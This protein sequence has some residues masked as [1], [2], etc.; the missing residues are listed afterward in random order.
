MLRRRCPA[1]VRLQ[2]SD[3][4]SASRSAPAS[5]DIRSSSGRA[6]VPS[7]DWNQSPAS[8]MTFS[9]VP[10]SSKRCVAPGTSF[11]ALSQD[12]TARACRFSPMTPWSSAPTISRVGAVT[13]AKCRA[14]EVGPTAA[15]DDR[16]HP[17]AERCRR[18]QSRGGPGAGAEEAERQAGQV[19][20]LVDPGDGV[21]QSVGEQANVE[22]LAAVRGLA[23][24]QQVEQQGGEASGVQVVGDGAIARAQSARATAVG[25][26]DDPPG[27]G[28]DLQ[29]AGQ[30]ERR[31]LDLAP[32][33]DAD[34]VRAFPRPR[35][36]AAEPGSRRR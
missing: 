5:P 17:R 33:D 12:R 24:G 29:I 35:P 1:K 34:A 25:K 32:L 28:R 7:L 14:G 20:L 11:I 30:P 23:L 2:R 3:A 9:S 27:I 8:S 15:R 31:Q 16:L 21:Q 22:D 13:L 4:P 6:D 10:G 26:Q 19:G 18:H 36:G